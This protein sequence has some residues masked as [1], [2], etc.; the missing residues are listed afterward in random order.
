MAVHVSRVP[1]RYI[2][3]LDRSGHRGANSQQSPETSDLSCLSPCN[4]LSSPTPADSVMACCRDA[5]WTEFASTKEKRAYHCRTSV[6]KPLHSHA[7][8]C[9][10]P[11]AAAASRLQPALQSLAEMVLQRMEHRKHP[12]DTLSHTQIQQRT[13]EPLP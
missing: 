7:C 4:N 13:T 1:T 10:E 5:C 8:P 3:S 11:S 2:T 6:S 9:L 12:L